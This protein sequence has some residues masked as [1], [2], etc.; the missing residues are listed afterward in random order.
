MDLGCLG[1][2]TMSA[3][4][5]SLMTSYSAAVVVRCLPITLKAL[6]VS[7]SGRRRMPGKVCLCV[8][9]YAAR[10]DRAKTETRQRRQDRD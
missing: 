8:H 6:P 9:I 3:R 7:T 1:G 10:Q 5:V 2:F 4:R